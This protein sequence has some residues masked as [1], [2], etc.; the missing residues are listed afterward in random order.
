MLFVA[1]YQYISSMRAV[2]KKHF[3]NDEKRAAI[4]QDI[5][6]NIN[7]SNDF[8]KRAI[9]S[10]T[11]KDSAAQFYIFYN[12]L[13]L[14]SSSYISFNISELLMLHLTPNFRASGPSANLAGPWI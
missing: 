6:E 1:N 5:R 4:E 11:S 3:S 13:L 7:L 8:V 2:R 10:S 12:F 14:V 9:D